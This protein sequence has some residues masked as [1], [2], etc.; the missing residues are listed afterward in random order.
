MVVSID[1]FGAGV[2]SLAYLG[3]L[4]VG[5]FKLDRSFITGIVGGDGER[6][7]HLVGSTVDLGHAMGLRIVAEGVEDAGTLSA[8]TDLGCDVAQGYF[9]ATPKPPEVLRFE[10]AVA[11]VLAGTTG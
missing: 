4:A 2:T 6:V 10:S 9:L 1:D 7:R 11:R 8:L 5:E 3:R